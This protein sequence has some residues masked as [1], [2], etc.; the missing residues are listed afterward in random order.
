MTSLAQIHKR[1]MFIY[2]L[3]NKSILFIIINIRSDWY[4][5]KGSNGITANSKNIESNG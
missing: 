5:Q 1:I 2:I 3:I 4:E